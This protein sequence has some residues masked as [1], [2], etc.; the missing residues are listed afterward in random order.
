MAE[1]KPYRSAEEA[2]L[3]AMMGE[4]LGWSEGEEGG[5][6]LIPEGAKVWLARSSE[7]VKP[8]G[9]CRLVPDRETRAVKRAC[10]DMLFVREAGQR[11]ELARALIDAALAAANADGLKGIWGYLVDSPG[12]DILEAT[13]GKKL[14]E[15]RLLRHD[16][17]NTFSPP[18]PP[19][20]YRLR[21]VSLPADLKPVADIY[22]E[23]FTEMWNFRSH[24]PDDIAEWFES[25][26]TSPEDC[27]ILE[28]DG[29][30]VGL[31]VLAVDPERQAHSDSAAY[32]PDIGVVST[33]RRKGLGGVLLAGCHRALFPENEPRTQFEVYDRMRSG[34]VPLEE[35]D[36]F[37]QPQPA[38]RNRL[39]Q[40]Q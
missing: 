32:I 35:P 39:T 24:G 36:V 37:G 23:T 29:E 1:A 26:D 4:A 5:G 10:L 18:R 8:D 12:Q 27:L 33:H 11:T 6:S 20:G 14:R 13:G 19:G 22:N 9:F 34:Y 7:D 28:Q 31:A 30:G 25:R 17:L 16:R 2:H 3:S 21:P 38:L 15:I 40:R